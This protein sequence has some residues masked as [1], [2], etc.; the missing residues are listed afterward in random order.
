MTAASADKGSRQSKRPTIFIIDYRQEVE[1]GRRANS[2]KNQTM[3]V[4]R[5]LKTVLDT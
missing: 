3:A 1:V 4:D 2:K 5:E